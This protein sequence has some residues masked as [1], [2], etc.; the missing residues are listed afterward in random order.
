MKRVVINQREYAWGDIRVYLFGQ[1]VGGLRGIDYKSTKNKDYVRGAG[2]RPRGIQ[3]GE[4][5]HEGTL[6]ILQSE[7]EALGRTAVAKGYDSILDLDFDIVVTYGTD[8]GVMTT[9]KIVQASIKELPKGM[10]GEDLYAEIAL[11]FIAL[12]IQEG[13]E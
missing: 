5:G 10:K 11:P 9:D 3:H 7:L 13:V 6:T 8:N 1:E 2:R 4:Y 12:D